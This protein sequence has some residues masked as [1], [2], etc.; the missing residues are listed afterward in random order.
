MDPPCLHILKQI[1]I[2]FVTGEDILVPR[3]IFLQTDLYKTMQEKGEIEALKKIFSSS[4]MTAL[5]KTASKE[6]MWPLLNLVRQILHVYGYHMKPIRKSDGYT[7]E[8]IKKY[9]RFF[10]ISKMIL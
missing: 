3:S 10:M 8:G 1:G 9:K 2:D 5:H 4:S 6:Q 7:L